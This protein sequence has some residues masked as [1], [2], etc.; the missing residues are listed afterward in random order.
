MENGGLKAMG[1]SED[2]VE[3]RLL[4]AYA[5]KRRPQP[6]NGDATPPP[7]KPPAEK[8]KKKKKTIK[9]K[10]LF[11]GCIHPEKEDSETS[12][13]PDALGDGEALGILADRLSKIVESVDLG[14]GDI[15]TDAPADD[16]QEIVDLLRESGDKLNEEFKRNPSL[17]QR[18]HR[19]FT[20]SLFE[21][22][23]TLFLQRVPL[24]EN[25][26]TKS[27]Q[28]GN[29]ALTCEVTRRLTAVDAHP[30]NMVM[31]FGAK[32]LQEHFSTWVQQRGGWEKALA[33]GEEDEDP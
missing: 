32:Y 26:S 20:Y 28:E 11:L 29:I 17:A 8:K 18:F 10:K 27:P 33:S 30:M 9:L 12:T 2:S 24:S 23:T 15:E 16:I 7:A 14:P 4:M 25:H 5:Q 22:I 31:G 6:T 13:D 1:A 3:F 21:R 19:D